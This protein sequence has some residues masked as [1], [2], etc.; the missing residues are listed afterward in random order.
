[1]TDS[2]VN[3]YEG[4]FARAYDQHWGSYA[5]ESGLRILEYFVSHPA[6]RPDARVLDLGCGSGQLALLF[7]QAGW[8]V[9]GV[10]RSTDML[11]LAQ[12]NCHSFV[13]TGKAVFHKADLRTFKINAPFILVTAT[14]N[15]MNHLVSE[16]DLSS[17]FKRT[18]E[19]LIKPGLFVFDLN[20][21]RGLRQWDGQ[22]RE[23]NERIAYVAKGTYDEERGQATLR[24]EGSYLR[25]DGNPEPFA[26]TTL[27]QA[28]DL[29]RVESLL[30]ASDFTKVHFSLPTDLGTPLKEPEKEMR[31]F[32][33]AEKV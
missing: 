4:S 24:M 6:A 27:N 30:K 13:T 31:V 28:F 20:T 7:L 25:A 16:S 5:R 15:V 26:H 33:V 8:G 11:A 18:H 14:Y 17:C 29:A 32:V 21:R 2:T 22:E 1:M 12:K 19:H 10:D 9:V 3:T 23:S